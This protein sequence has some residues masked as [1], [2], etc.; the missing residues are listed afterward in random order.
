[1]TSWELHNVAP[2]PATDSRPL[3][4]FIHWSVVS[5][6]GVIFTGY[7]KPRSKVCVS[8]NIFLFLENRVKIGIEHKFIKLRNVL[9]RLF[10]I[11]RVSST[12]K[13]RYEHKWLLYCF[14]CIRL[15]DPDSS[16][17]Q[18]VKFHHYPNRQNPKLAVR[19]VKSEAKT[20]MHCN[21]K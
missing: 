7:T 16:S 20:W 3:Y 17:L 2:S 14:E 19:K 18:K 6:Q 11:Y 1:M 13:H 9:S 5:G 8:L 12:Y 10:N 4:D 15:F 21:Q